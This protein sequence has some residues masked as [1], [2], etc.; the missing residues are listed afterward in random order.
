MNKTMLA[1]L[2]RIAGGAL[3]TLAA[4]SAA[5]MRI[6]LASMVLFMSHFSFGGLACESSESSG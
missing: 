5:A 2:I 6:N 1:R 4:V 3:L